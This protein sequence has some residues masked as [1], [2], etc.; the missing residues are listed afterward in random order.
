MIIS[1]RPSRRVLAV[2]AGAAVLAV[3]AAGC[4]TSL[5]SSVS[6]AP[7]LSVATGLYPLAQIADLIGQNKA[8]VTDVIPSGANPLSYQ[9]TPAEKDQVRSSGLVI[10]IGGGFQPSFEAAASAAGTVSKLRPAGA[11]SP[12][13]WL[14]PHTLSGFV[15]T[16]AAAMESADPGAA[17]LYRQ[18]AASLRAQ[19]SSLDISYSSTLST[20][21]DTTL[22]TPDGAFATMAASYGLKDIVV[23]A[24][25]VAS[26]IQAATRALQAGRT[27]AVITEP[28]VDNSGVTAVAA[29]ANAKIHSLDTLAGPPS[30]GWPPGADYFGLM[31][32]NLST[33][34]SILGCASPSQ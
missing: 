10:E 4:G 5:P 2:F 1:D 26:Q 23:G 17:P 32:Q 19:I 14:D 3:A 15:T 8:V 27:T 25:S 11:A 16:V 9:L 30:G 18:N 31:E 24:P 29:A 20:C 21:P 12:Y 34:G 33:L 7:V 6:R 28:W 22:I 13:V